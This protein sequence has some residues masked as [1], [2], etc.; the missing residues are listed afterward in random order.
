MES[1]MASKTGILH[2]AD[3]DAV[4]V[5]R[6]RIR[7]LGQLAG[8]DLTLLEVEVPPGSGTP[9]HFHASPETFRVL[10]GEIA[11]GLF[12]DEA[13]SEVTAG[14]GTVVTVPS[15]VPHSYRNAG[16][17]PASLL[18]VVERPMVEFFRDLGRREAPPAGPPGEAE[19]A[20]VMAA[21]ARHGV[22][23]L[24]GPPA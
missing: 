10:S 19:I 24:G 2:P 22:T 7:F 20:A 1:L 9:P 5:V 13:P 17:A 16:A 14:A 12:G 4:W 18:V 23:I 21:C 15:G 6:D 3:A 8:T 11:F